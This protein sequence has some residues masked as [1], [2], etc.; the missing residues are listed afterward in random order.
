MLAHVSS[1]TLTLHRILA[2][3]RPG[4]SLLTAV[5]VSL[6]M[7]A[8]QTAPPPHRMLHECFAI[9]SPASLDKNLLR[10]LDVIF[11]ETAPT[12]VHPGCATAA[13]GAPLCH[14]IHTTSSTPNP[15]S[16][17]PVQ[18]I[19]VHRRMTHAVYTQMPSVDTTHWEADLMQATR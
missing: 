1:W 2:A 9:R 6:G 12:A 7:L 17:L 19:L 16:L 4:D 10:P 14:S 8:G 3:A 18:S 11:G 5:Q 13:D 15:A